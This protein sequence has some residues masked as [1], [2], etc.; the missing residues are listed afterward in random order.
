MKRL[1]GFLQAF[2]L[3]GILNMSAGGIR[4]A[5]VAGKTGLSG[6]EIVQGG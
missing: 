4:I 2:F 1:A 6:H 3:V 5:I